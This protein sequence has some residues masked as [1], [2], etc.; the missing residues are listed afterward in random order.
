MSIFDTATQA[1]QVR[2]LKA[3]FF[4]P[5]K[6]GKTTLA[7]T[8]PKPV[9]LDTEG[10]TMS[11]RDTPGIDILPITSWT[12]LNEAVKEL[13]LGTQHG[14]KSV[15]LDSV[16]L[17][18]EVAGAEA[19]LLAAIV[20]K[21]QDPRSAYGAIGAMIR[22]KII[23]L[24]NLP[25]HVV[26]TAQLRERDGADME[27]G[28]YPLTPDVTPSILKTLMAA[29]DVIGRTAI[30]QVGAEP[31]DVEHQVFFGPESRSQVG[32]RNLGLPT[33][34]KNLT[35]PSLISLTQQEK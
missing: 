27:A 10:G 5:S 30:V 35:I 25:L 15:V 34:A 8:A 11:L 22:H 16:T 31:T 18:Q 17:L 23:Q 7:G 28:Q 13:T 20:A 9:F 33:V 32:H 3:L 21:D 29:P 19:G 26:F 24:N 2:P 14:Y 1:G 4:G 6:S 12:V